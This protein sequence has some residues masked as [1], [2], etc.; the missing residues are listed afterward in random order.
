MWFVVPA[1]AEGWEAHIEDHPTNPVYFWAIDKKDQK[2]LAFERKSPLVVVEEKPCTTG[3]AAGDKIV[4]G[5]LKTP[6]GVYFVT[7]RRTGNLDFELYGDLA[8][9]LN[10]PNPVDRLNG[11]T[12]SGI[13][14]HGRGRGI[15][16]RET[17]GCVALNQDDIHSV[18]ASAF[19]GMPVVIAKDIVWPAQER[20]EGD[21]PD[22]LMGTLAG[23]TEAWSKESPEFFSFYDPK[24][25]AEAQRTTFSRFR[26]HKLGVFSRTPWIDVFVTDVRLL[27]GPGYW[28][29]WFGQ[30]YR[31]A[32]FTSAITK[33]LYWQRDDNGRFRIVGVETTAPPVG[34]KGKYLEQAAHKAEQFIDAWRTAWEKADLQAY[35]DFYLPDA[36]QD[37]RS[38]IEQIAGHKREI[39]AKNPP[40]SV[41]LSGLRVREHPK[42]LEL[43]V[44][45]DYASENGYEDRGIKRLIIR[46]EGSNWKII[47]ETWTGS[48]S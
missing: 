15:V 17:R 32:N 23:W 4:E 30:Y 28:V 29:T 47:K 16:P 12:G 45:Q 3:Q 24:K 25:Y 7:G 37:A 35:A 9:P 1:F 44:L 36:Q 6:E 34:L 8:F 42:G 13:W 10:Y 11:K 48:T 14:V 2:F 39:W 43:R 20:I 33:R 40:Q 41:A 26:D 5:D 18:E 22:E 38:G 19:R 46:P 21:V 31:S 27:P